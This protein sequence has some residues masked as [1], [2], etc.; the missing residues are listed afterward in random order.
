MRTPTSRIVAAVVALTGATADAAIA[1]TVQRPMVPIAEAI[2]GAVASLDAAIAE[3]LRSG[4]VESSASGARVF[5]G[6]SKERI[7]ALHESAAYEQ[8]ALGARAPEHRVRAL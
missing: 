3:E 5:C 6:R 1:V 7:S 2:S 8:D 4:C